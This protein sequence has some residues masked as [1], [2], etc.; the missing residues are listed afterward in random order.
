MILFFALLLFTV[1]VTTLSSGGIPILDVTDA[2]LAKASQMM[3]DGDDEKPK[4]CEFF[5]NFQ[6]HFERT[7]PTS[8]SGP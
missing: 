6:D 1:E 7:S 2:D 8:Q 3:R 5:V 4:F